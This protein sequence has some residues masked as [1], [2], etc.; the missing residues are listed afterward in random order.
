M[1]TEVNNQ[2]SIKKG[3]GPIIVFTGLVIALVVVLK[4]VFH[5]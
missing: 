2:K 4:V 5:M 1:N 3:F